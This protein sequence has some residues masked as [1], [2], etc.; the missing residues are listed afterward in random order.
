MMGK[1]PIDLV[2]SFTLVM[3][4]TAMK[5]S[6]RSNKAHEMPRVLCDHYN[7]P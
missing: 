2:E 5:A 3:E 7:K 1:K 4:Q 6:S